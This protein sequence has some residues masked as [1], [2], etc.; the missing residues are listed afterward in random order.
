MQALDL[1]VEDKNAI[2][3]AAKAARLLTDNA[4]VS[5]E[6]DISGLAIVDA[7]NEYLEIVSQKVDDWLTAKTIHVQNT[8]PSDCLPKQAMALHS[9]MCG[10]VQCSGVEVMLHSACLGECD[11]WDAMQ[12]P[13]ADC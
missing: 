3:D 5:Q 1:D 6:M 10:C 7:D 8:D 4:A 2:P 13:G 11:P 9:E 12:Q